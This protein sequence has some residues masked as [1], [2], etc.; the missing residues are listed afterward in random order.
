MIESLFKAIADQTLQPQHILF[1]DSSSTDDTLA[2]IKQ[3]NFKYHVIPKAEFNHGTTRQ[4]AV[5]LVDADIYIFMTQ[6]AVLVTGNSFENL[7]VAFHDPKIGC[8]YGRQLPMQ[9]ANRLAQHVRLFN[10]PEI[11]QVKSYADRERLGI[12]TCFCSDSFAAYRKEALLEVGGF[13]R[14]IIFGEDMYVAAKMLLKGWKVAYQAD[15]TVYHSHNYTLGQE[16]KR[17]FDIG[18]FH[19]TND[20]LI[21]AFGYPTNEGLKYVKSELLYCCKEKAYLSCFQSIITIFAKYFGYKFGKNYK[22]IPNFLRKKIGMHGG[23][24]EGK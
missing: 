3:H 11:S 7:L 10:Y 20:W 19:T 13:P 22:L 6:D 17:Y 2:Q 14:N 8:A 5:S 1:V 16:F 18:V 24:W 23:Y 21:K 12:K 9:N 15:T 4:L